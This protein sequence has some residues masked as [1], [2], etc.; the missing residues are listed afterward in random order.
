[1]KIDKN[2]MRN[3]KKA[4]N[5]RKFRCKLISNGLLWMNITGNSRELIKTNILRL[6]PMKTNGKS[7]K[8]I[9]NSFRIAENPFKIA[10]NYWNFLEKEGK[11]ESD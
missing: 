3:E 8:I 4:G 6:K 10:A 1:M 2:P 7:M 9:I 5:S 11:L